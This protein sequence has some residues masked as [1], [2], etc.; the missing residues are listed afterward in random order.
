MITQA[1]LL[2]LL[3][4]EPDEG[5]FYWLKKGRGIRPS[6]NCQA[7]SF[8]AHG[9]GQIRIDGMVYKEHRLVWLYVHGEF[10]KNQIDHANHDRRDNRIEN[11]RLVDNIENHKNRPKQNNNKTGM[12]GVCYDKRGFYAAY[13]TVNGER[14]GLGYYKTIDGAKEARMAAN[15]KYGYH[16]NHGVGIGQRRVDPLPKDARRSNAF[17]IEFDGRSMS[18]TE[19]AKQDG[20]TASDGMIR[21]RV[22]RGWTAKEA[23]FTP[24]VTYKHRSVKRSR[25]SNGTF[26]AIDELKA[27][28]AEYAGKIKQLQVSA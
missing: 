20:V 1:R 4:Y 12:P 11:L 28:K 19:W 23:I 5:R 21:S 26:A 7:G 10:P 17:V 13:I 18:A 25:N 24:Y 14:I 27:I 2:E 8:D 22:K 15:V 3:R 6:R 9:Y 16:A